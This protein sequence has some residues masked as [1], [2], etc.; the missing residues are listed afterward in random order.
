MLCCSLDPENTFENKLTLP[1]PSVA[2]SKP[3]CA[4]PAKSTADDDAGDVYS[5]L[6]AGML[7]IC[8]VLYFEFMQFL[9]LSIFVLML[10]NLQNSMS[11]EIRFC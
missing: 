7:L 9:S 4:V 6:L 11:E 2:V 1:A 10:Y 5:N 3:H 8:L